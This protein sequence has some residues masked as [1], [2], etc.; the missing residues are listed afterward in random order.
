MAAIDYD[1]ILAAVRELIPDAGREVDVLKYDN[2]PADPD[3]PWEGA[4][5]PRDTADIV[6]VWAVAVQPSGLAE[7]GIE[8]EL[9]GDQM[10]NVAEVL[11]CEPGDDQGIDLS[12][13]DEVRDGGQ[14]HKIE[15]ASKLRPAGTT[16]L[17]FLGV[18]K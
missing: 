11:V 14:T 2:T 4:A 15:W 17:Y 1:E 18:S 5:D 6:T 9:D 3:K 7:L 10:R 13:Y 16:L 12:T 8:V